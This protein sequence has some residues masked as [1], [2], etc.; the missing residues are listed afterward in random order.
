M[1]VAK[2]RNCKQDPAPAFIG[3]LTGEEEAKRSRNAPFVGHASRCLCLPRAGAQS[4]SRPQQPNPDAVAELFFAPPRRAPPVLPLPLPWPDA[5]FALRHFQMGEKWK[6]ARHQR[7]F[8]AANVNLLPGPA[9]LVSITSSVGAGERAGGGPGS[10]ARDLTQ[11][12]S[13]GP[14]INYWICSCRSRT[15]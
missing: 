10:L 8:S 14:T 3:L 4:D 2:L 5:L 7:S 6:R 15:R 12:K 9:G 13:C 1:T 11:L